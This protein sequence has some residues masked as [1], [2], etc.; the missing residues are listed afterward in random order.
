MEFKDVKADADETQRKIRYTVGK[1]VWNPSLHCHLV[2][3]GN[4][5]THL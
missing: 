3:A 1:S 5:L 2:T 4:S